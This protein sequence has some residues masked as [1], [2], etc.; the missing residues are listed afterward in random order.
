MGSPTFELVERPAHAL[1]QVIE[2]VEHAHDLLRRRASHVLEAVAHRHAAL[3]DDVL[4]ARQ[5]VDPDVA[6]A[7]GQVQ[8]ELFLTKSQDYGIVK[9]LLND[10]PVGEFDLWSGRGVEPTGELDLGEV[11]LAGDGDVLRLTV[12]GPNPRAAAPFF[13]FGVD[14][15][16]L[17]Q[18]E[19][20]E[21]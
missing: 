13:Q 20:V 17:E 21:P 16:R 3:Q 2:L 12:G 6:K 14:G 11:E 10:N 15:I 18:V 5:V 19:P 4:P 9:V 7:R 1:D 8:A